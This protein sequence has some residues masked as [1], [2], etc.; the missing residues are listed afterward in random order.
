MDYPGLC[1]W[2]LK[3]GRRINERLGQRKG[4]KDEAPQGF[5]AVA[6]SENGTSSRTREQSLQQPVRKWGLHF[7]NCMALEPAGLQEPGSGFS[8]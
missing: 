4:T 2:A 6:G 3:E 1:G 7:H 5:S 8:R